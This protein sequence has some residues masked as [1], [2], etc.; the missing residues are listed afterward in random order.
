MVLIM[1]IH[2]NI[3]VEIDR[4]KHFPFIISSLSEIVEW[5][6]TESTGIWRHNSKVT[7]PWVPAAEKN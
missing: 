7:K 6:L 4:T 2:Y 1:Q 3:M 5:C